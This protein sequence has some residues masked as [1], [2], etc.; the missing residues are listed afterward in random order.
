V[1]WGRG[2]R[3]LE[4]EREGKK[5][6]RE[7]GRGGREGREGTDPSRMLITSRAFPLR[8]RR[9]RPVFDHRNILIRFYTAD[10]IMRI[11]CKA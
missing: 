6:G 1:G 10:N 4:G 3:D 5:R 2:E 11:A 8:R 9:Q 7:G